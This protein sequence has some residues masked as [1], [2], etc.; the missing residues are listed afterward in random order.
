MG[1]STRIRF[2]A[3]RLCVIILDVCLMISSVS[4]KDETL[5][6]QMCLS[7]ME[8]NSIA[9][10]ILDVKFSLKNETFWNGRNFSQQ[11]VHL[12]VDA[13]KGM[14]HEE[15]KSYNT[16]PIDTNDYELVIDT[17]NGEEYVSW[18]RVIS[19]SPGFRVLGQG[20]YEHPGGVV[21]KN[22]TPFYGELPYFLEF[23]FEEFPRSFAETVPNQ[24]PRLVLS[25]NT[26]IIETEWNKF[27][28]SK[29]TGILEKLF[30]YTWDKDDQRVI[31]QTYDFS[32]HIELSGI[33]IPL[34]IIGKVWFE[35]KVI[36]KVDISVD[37]TTLRLLDKMDDP[38]IFN[39]VLPAGCAVKDQIR[40]KSYIVTTADT[41]PNDV[42]ALRQ[43]LEKMLE[44]AQEQAEE[45]VIGDKK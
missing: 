4:A 17:W 19:T 41:L 18:T 21:I 32:N 45:K 20:I 36:S 12:V 26:I 37:S 7:L 35:N 39:E 23:N 38:S 11:D 34:N 15:T 44:Q 29:K 9:R 8:R 5:D 30:F 13:N 24:N 16:N 31:G 33:W 22:R 42:E 1:K 40:K 10:K 27:E 14:Y 3:I 25:G 2:Y 28:F 43:V 6:I